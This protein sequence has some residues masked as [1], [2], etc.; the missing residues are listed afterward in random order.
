MA[1]V[2]TDANGNRT[3]QVVCGDGKRRPIRLGKASMRQAEAVRVMVEDL[4]HAAATGAAPQPD[5]SI[6]VALLTDDML[7]KFSI[8][9][10]TAP[11]ESARLGPFLDG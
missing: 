2:S 11:R 8:I 5:T 3:T 6:W 9:G 1:S 10:L 4:A 7:E